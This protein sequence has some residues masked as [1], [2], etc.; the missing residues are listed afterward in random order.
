MNVSEHQPLRL[1]TFRTENEE[2]HSHK[3]SNIWKYSGLKSIEFNCLKRFV[4]GKFVVEL[5][6]VISFSRY[7]L[8]FLLQRL[9]FGEKSFQRAQTKIWTMIQLIQNDSHLAF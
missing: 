7:C 8:S 5:N 6:F 2:E 1:H 9:S 4:N 3:K